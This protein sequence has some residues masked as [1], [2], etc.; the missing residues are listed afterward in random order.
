[1]TKF[2]F[3]FPGQGSQ[4]IA[5]G[6]DFYDTFAI[7]RQTFELAE[8]IL[9]Y[10]ITDILFKGPKDLLMQTK[11]SQLAIFITS[12]AILHTISQQLPEVNCEICAGLSLGEY[13]ALCA[14]GYLSF[15]IALK[16]VR[17]RAYFMNDACEKTPGTMAAVLGLDRDKLEEII[18]PI[19]ST[20]KVWIAN[21]NCPSQ[22]VLSGDKEGI[23]YAID[24]LK[25]NQAK[26]IPLVVHGAF[27]SKL[28]ECAQKNLAP[29]IQKA[30]FTQGNVDIVMNVPGDFVRDIDLIKKYLIEQVTQPVRWEQ[31]IENITKHS[32][33][34]YLEIGG[35]KTLTGMNKKMNLS[36]KTTSIGSVLELDTLINKMDGVFC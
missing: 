12:M 9:A 29:K 1:M 2:A 8:D 4:Y 17:D 21:Y 14:G 5:M 28:M 11:H 25:K 3:L 24:I 35:G 30:P 34:H 33:D 23:A 31:S 27:H 26:V 7:A 6:K 18:S 36:S 19:S 32:V 16:L 20:H 13:T 15:E 22:M 10:K